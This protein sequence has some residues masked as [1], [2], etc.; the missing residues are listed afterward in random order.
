MDYPLSKIVEDLEKED[1]LVSVDDNGTV[2]GVNEVVLLKKRAWKLDPNTKFKDVAVPIPTIKEGEDLYKIAKLMVENK[3]YELPYEDLKRSIHYKDL[4]KKAKLRG[5]I[6]NFFGDYID[7]DASEPVLTVLYEMKR[8]KVS[9][10]TV[11]ENHY[12]IGVV[13]LK[14][15]FSKIIFPKKKPRFGEAVDEYESIYRL[16]IKNFIVDVTPLDTT[17]I[18]EVKEALINSEARAIPIVRGRTYIGTITVDELLKALA[19]KYGE[20]EFNVNITSNIEL[21]D[22]DKE[23][24]KKEIE[25]KIWRRFKDFLETATI[26]LDIRREKGVDPDNIEYFWHV[27]LRLWSPR[28]K[29]VVETR[30][31]SMYNA[32]K[33]AIKELAEE[34]LRKKREVEWQEL[35][36]EY[37]NQILG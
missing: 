15:V 34:I 29:F 22:E 17:D 20:A 2:L 1:L 18:E 30:G 13:S 28:G 36:E 35:L 16:P 27:R 23:F 4:L 31:V 3:F 8:K 11:L 37:I 21:L 6:T 19:S 33:M 12:P 10:A 14:E 24:I 26:Y 25:K 9:F 5:E 7:V 32:I